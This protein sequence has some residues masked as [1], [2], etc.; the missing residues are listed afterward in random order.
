MD[1]NACTCHKCQPVT[2][3]YVEMTDFHALA[4]RVATLEQWR[5]ARLAD[6]SMRVAVLE[7]TYLDSEK[8]PLPPPAAAPDALL[9]CPFCGDEGATEFPGTV[10]C[11]TGCAREMNYTTWQRRTPGDAPLR[12]LAEAVCSALVPYGPITRKVD[13]AVDNLHA[14]LEATR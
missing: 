11:R 8:V 10:R 5:E 3:A 7:A 14:H 1:S 9:P 6:L 2:P 13:T 4:A 12:R